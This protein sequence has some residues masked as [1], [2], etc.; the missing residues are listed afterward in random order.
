[1]IIVITTIIIIHLINVFKKK[2]IEKNEKLYSRGWENV[3]I[4]NKV[5]RINMLKY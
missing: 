5:N 4:L 3:N 1:M 2:N